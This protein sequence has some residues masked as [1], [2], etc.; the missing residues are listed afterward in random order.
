MSGEGSLLGLD[1]AHATAEIGLKNQPRKVR[2]PKKFKADAAQSVAGDPDESSSQASA[3]GRR[4]QGRFRF[5]L[6]VERHVVG[7]AQGQG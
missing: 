6:I 4:R 1:D 5:E 7:H 2:G 3:S